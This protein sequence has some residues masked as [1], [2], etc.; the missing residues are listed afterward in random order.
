MIQKLK[1]GF[2]AGWDDGQEAMPGRRLL[3]WCLLFTFG[4]GLLAHAYGFLHDSFSHDVLNALVADNVETYWKM[5]LGR[6]SAV[7]YR[8]LIRGPVTMP[9]LLGLL[10]LLWT[11]L[12]LFLTAKLLRIRSRWLLALTAGV[13]A[14]NISFIALTATYIYE[15]DIDLLALLGAAA[16]AFLW[17]RYGWLGAALGTLF[18]T[19]SLSLY[20][21]YLC[22]AVVLIML[23][24]I[25][26]LLDGAR[27]GAVFGRGLRGV[28]MIGVGGGIYYVLLQLMA[29]LKD[30]PLDT[31]SYNSVYTALD[32]SGKSETLLEAIGAAYGDW[33]ASFFDPAS[34]FLT[35]WMQRLHLVMAV[36]LAVLLIAVLLSK[37]IR[38][39]EKALL[40]VL[41][42]LLPLGS[43]ATRILSGH[44]VHDLMKFAFWLVYLLLML[45]GRW[46]KERLARPGRAVNAL[47]LLLVALLLWQN[48]QTANA[49]YVKKDLEQDAA[50]S[51]MTRV[52]DRIEQTE[53]Y[54]PGETELCF[55]G[56]SDQLLPAISGFG[57]Y[58]KIT[59]LEGGSP[60]LTANAEYYY[61]AYGA[62]FKYIL[63]NPGRMAGHKTWSELQLD[64]RALAMPAF[65]AAGCIREI[66]GVLVVK[67]GEQF[68]WGD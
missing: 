51:L 63:N 32:A 53:G 14:V 36:L 22:V 17:A 44:A 52:V 25:Q 33:A 55:V 21:S 16:A 42:L 62:Y 46:A 13:L 54:V 31:G 49:C 65:P 50:L 35:P 30:I 45:L 28:G 68:E 5:Q 56:V 29:K 34:A 20:Q 7:L 39:A 26:E 27:F 48:V 61:N 41:V 40:A 9:W 15:L 37:S 57:E 2:L 60:I 59:G 3:F 47:A 12:T 6:F 23:V 18:I 38:P 58:Q 43:N 24:C 67:M 11:A 8:R 19:G 10:G 66:D 1:R 64:E 4:W